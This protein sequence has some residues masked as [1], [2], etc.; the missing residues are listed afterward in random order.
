M[1]NY[2]QFLVPCENHWM[3]VGEEDYSEDCNNNM[4]WIALAGCEYFSTT[5]VV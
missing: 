1:K 5:A 2:F 4:A 3:V